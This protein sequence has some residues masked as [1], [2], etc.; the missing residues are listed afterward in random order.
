M[1]WTWFGKEYCKLNKRGNID[2]KATMTHELESY[3]DVR[4]VRA[5]MVSSTY[6]AV[7]KRKRDG[8]HMLVVCLT[9]V[10]NNWRNPENFGYK[11]MDDSM[12][13]Y[14]RDCPKAILDL[15]DELCPP[16]NEWAR[17]WREDCRENLLVKNSPT[18]FKNVRPGESVLWHVPQDSRLMMGGESLAGKTMRLTKVKGRRSWIH[19][20][21]WNTRIPTKHV[22]PKDC[23]ILEA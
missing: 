3:G 9:Q 2:R 12:G 17:K 18:A 22:N 6:Y 4:V 15:A 20:G 23:E 1:G 5:Q 7:I 14:E 16:T 8:E 13:P 19:K 21:L 10:N 11:D